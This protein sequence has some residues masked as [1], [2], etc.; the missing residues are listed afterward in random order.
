MLTIAEATAT[1]TTLHRQVKRQTPWGIADFAT[2]FGPGVTF[3]T[4]PSH[5]GFFVA[6]PDA[7][8]ESLRKRSDRYCGFQWYEED[9]EAALVVVAHPELFTPD[10]RVR[11]LGCVK[12]FYPTQH[13]A[14]LLT[15]HY[16][17][18][19]DGAEVASCSK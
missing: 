6:T 16:R 9:C 19:G 3:Y 14:Y 13:A 1:R 10:E 18:H 15:E 4:T 17:Q 8:P 2:S 11:A 12:A 5:G 7:M